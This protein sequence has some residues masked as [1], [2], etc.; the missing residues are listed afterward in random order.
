MKFQV[1]DGEKYQKIMEAEISVEEMDLPIKLACKRLAEKVNI[2]GFRKGKAPRSVLES[3]IG[4][5]AIL[6]EAADGILG[7]AYV[8]GLKETGLEPVAKP[9][10][11]ITQLEAGQPMKFKAVITVKPEVKLG[12]YQELP[13]TRRVVK[14]NEEDIDR[15]LARQQQRL[16]KLVDAPE[17]AEATNGDT[18]TIDFKGLKDGVAFEGGTAENYPLTLGGNSFIPGFEDQLLGAEKG[19]QRQVEVTFPEDYQEQSLAGQPVV[20]EVTVKE[21]K[22]RQMPELDE[23]FVQE[24]SETAETMEQLREDVRKYLEEGSLKT[25][26]ENGRVDAVAQ[27]VEN[28]EADIPPVM[29]EQQIDQIVAETNQRLQSQG[30]S[31]EKFLEYTGQTMDQIRETYQEQARFM[32]KRD[33]VIEAVA[34]AENIQAEEADVEAEIQKLSVNYWQP[35]EKIREMLEKNGRLEDLKFSIRMQ[36]AAEFIYAN[37]LVSDEI[38]DREQ[39]IR[40][41]AQ[42]AQEAADQDEPELAMPEETDAEAGPAAAAPEQENPAEPAKE[43]G[44]E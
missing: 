33:L 1:S 44:G 28:A 39:M 13:V 30:L 14:I 38:V 26:D 43:A 9:E 7:Q 20:F 11:D 5:P 21:I 6:E 22:V 15:D 23:A 27:A 35:P 32:V 16:S 41:A 12:Q 10:V 37:A 3:F 42:A 8:E 2:P 19:E 24:V 4:L 36:K 25:A 34:D 31:F 29:V 40:D 18:V 17:G